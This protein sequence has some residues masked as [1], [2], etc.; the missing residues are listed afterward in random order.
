[1]KFCV[2]IWGTSLKNII[3]FANFCEK[4]NF[5]AI[6]YGEGPFDWIMDNT[7]ILSYLASKTNKIRLGPVVSYIIKGY[8]EPAFIAKLVASL[9][10]ISN[11]RLDLRFGAGT[12][13]GKYYWESYGI[14]YPSSI[15]RIEQ[16][17]EGIEILKLLFE[18]DNVNYKGKY[19]KIKNAKCIPK[20][21]QKPYPEL[22]ISAM[23]INMLRLAAKH[24]NVW[25]ASYLPL[26]KYEIISEKFEKICSEIGRK[27]I[28]KSI[29]LDVVVAMN[30][31]DLKKKYKKYIQ[32]R[33]VDE[34][35]DVVKSCIKG[36]PEDC[37]KIVESYIKLGVERFT[38]A[39]NNFP[40]TDD[41]E[42]FGEH[43]IPYFI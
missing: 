3:K 36:K 12:Q 8:R 29:E 6:Y 27:N 26:N 24:A 28:E 14:P 25:E 32:I 13:A 35:H 42:I 33:M 19:F 43:V 39:F 30:D 16:L 5:H 18:M 40:E 34:N 21:L 23:N 9:D 41:L 22:H 15:E 11:G 38:L 7:V 2:Q 37:I 1:V 10:I 20:P 31:E 4:Y 17:D